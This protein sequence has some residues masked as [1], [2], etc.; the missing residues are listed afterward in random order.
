MNDRLKGRGVTPEIFE[1]EYA[2]S[3]WA[4]FCDWINKDPTWVN[5]DNY[6]AFVP[7]QYFKE[8]KITYQ[9]LCNVLKPSFVDRL[10]RQ[11]R[12]FREEVMAQPEVQKM[13]DKERRQKSGKLIYEKL[14]VFYKS[15]Y[16]KALAQEKGELYD[17]L[18]ADTTKHNVPSREQQGAVRAQTKQ[19]DWIAVDHVVYESWKFNTWDMRNAL[20]KVSGGDVLSPYDNP[21]EDDEVDE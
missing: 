12:V 9:K 13:T 16:E 14:Q 19:S 21:R 15:A 4:L 8:N 5:K 3:I 7:S 11:F 1:R 18:T 20:Y 2:W 6:K 17:V 10:I